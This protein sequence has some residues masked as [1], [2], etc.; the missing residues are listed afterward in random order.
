M[1]ISIY[2]SWIA[3]LEMLLMV[4][5]SMVLQRQIAQRRAHQLRTEETCGDEIGSRRK[6]ICQTEA[7]KVQLHKKRDT[8]GLDIGQCCNDARTRENLV[9][10]SRQAD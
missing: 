8:I 1:F 10:E 7:G 3:V 4:L 9:W 5:Y 6:S 2:S